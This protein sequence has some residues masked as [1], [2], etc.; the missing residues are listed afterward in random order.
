MS[1]NW[2]CVHVLINHQSSILLTLLHN[3]LVSS[4]TILVTL[5]ACTLHE[6]YMM[7]HNTLSVCQHAY[8]TLLN[9]FSDASN[10][11]MLHKFTWHFTTHLCDASQCAN[12]MLHNTLMT[13]CNMSTSQH[14]YVTLPACLRDT[15]LW[16]LQCIYIMHRNTSRFA[17]PFFIILL[18]LLGAL[19]CT[20][21]YVKHDL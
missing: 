16:C 17:T 3:M 4:L 11:I 2:L 1:L 7:L 13:L 18:C 20:S 6:A 12:V 14:I 8:V 15:S 21:V 10:Q 5:N 19:L 9:T